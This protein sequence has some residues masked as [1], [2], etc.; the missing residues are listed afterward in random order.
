MTTPKPDIIERVRELSPRWHDGD[1][2]AE[3]IVEH[4]PFIAEALLK[5][6]ESLEKLADMEPTPGVVGNFYQATQREAKNALSSI[7]SL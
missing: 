4:F 3:E 6:V 7:R 2:S 5:A 1:L